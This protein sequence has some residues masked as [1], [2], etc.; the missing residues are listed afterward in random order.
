MNRAFVPVFA[1]NEDDR[2]A[3]P[4][5]EEDKAEYRRI[6]REARRLIATPVGLERAP[7][8]DAAR[9]MLGDIA[10]AWASIA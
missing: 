3:G 1:V 8:L 5:P 10:G 6:Y 4:A 9:T 7:A 2:D